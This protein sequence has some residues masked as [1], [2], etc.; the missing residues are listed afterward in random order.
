MSLPPPSFTLPVVGVSAFQVA[1]MF[2]S[3][4]AICAALAEEGSMQT[5][6]AAG[7]PDPVYPVGCVMR[8]IP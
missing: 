7:P 5:V 8:P 2:W 4:T 3:G 6:T 1:A